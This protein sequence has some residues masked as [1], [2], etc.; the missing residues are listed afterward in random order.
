MPFLV[1]FDSLYYH[2]PLLYRLDHL[3]AKTQ[4]VL[5]LSL[6]AFLLASLTT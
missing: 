4:Q 2:H 6:S 3:R 1:I 5:D